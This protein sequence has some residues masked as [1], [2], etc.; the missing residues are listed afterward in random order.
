MSP[1]SADLPRYVKTLKAAGQSKPLTSTNNALKPSSNPD[2]SPE[3]DYVDNTN[4]HTES[5]VSHTFG[6]SF[7]S[8]LDRDPDLR[9][10]FDASMQ[11]NF[12]ITT[13]NNAHSNT[14]S[15]HRPIAR[16]PWWEK[17][18]L[19]SELA[20]LRSGMPEPSEEKAPAVVDVGGGRGH[21]IAALK[22]ARPGLLR[23][24]RLV[25]Q[26]MAEPIS[27]ARENPE[28]AGAGIE[29]MEHDF[30]KPQPIKGTSYKPLQTRPTNP[31]R[32]PQAHTYTT[33]ATSCTT[34]PTT[35]PTP[36]SRTPRTPWTPPAPAS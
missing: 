7:W 23:N 14:S 19:E 5:L 21:F 9:S 1:I 33:S 31:P 15:N 32:P 26:D 12:S 16:S 29:C 34:S 25:L 13:A 22:A 3:T 28:V 24:E 10:A 8:L 6:Q 18:P 20:T 36:S 27:K 17:Y 2:H 35:T 30:L 4:I 11:G